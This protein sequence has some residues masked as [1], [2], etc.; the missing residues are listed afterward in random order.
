M[1][2]NVTL[3]AG[4]G[5]VALAAQDESS[6]FYQEVKLTASGSG[7]TEALSK[8]EDSAHSSGEHGILALAVRNDTLAALA[9]TDG[10]YAVLQVNDLGALF[11]DLAEFAGNA[12]NLGNGAVGTGTLRVTIASDTTGVLSVD[13]NGA[14]LSVDWGGTVPPIGAGTEA[15]ALRVTIATDST[16]LLSIDD[17][18]GSLTVDNG[19]TFVI[20]EDGAALTALQLIDN[21]VVVE[22]A[23]AAA[24][25]T[26]NMMM[27]VRD[28]EVGSTALTT[29]DNDLQALRSNRFGEL[30]VTQI[31]DSTS[32]FKYAIIDAASSGNNTIQ[33]AAGS[34]IKIRVLA[35][36]LVSAGTVNARFESAADGTALTGQ[37][38]LVV[39]SGF[40]LPFNPAG[41]FE[42]GD[43]ALL[44]LEL[45]AGVSVDGCITYVEI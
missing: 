1:A 43:D 19:G 6:V 31:P 35:A 10:D 7:T 27:S 29:A 26:G 39:N 3:N 36:F 38:N 40:T 30:K 16:G 2:D 21:V 13:D 42:T 8:A 22:D 37:M 41:W 20:Q 5:G 45:S 15:A 33:A 17:N 44:N 32:E 9:G 18:G 12:V 34:G 23:A 14:N 28:D 11:V 4:S 25:P 24:N